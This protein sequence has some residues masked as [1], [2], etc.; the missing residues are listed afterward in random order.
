MRLENPKPEDIT[1]ALDRSVNGDGSIFCIENLPNVLDIAKETRVFVAGDWLA[2]GTIT[3]LTSESGHGKSYFSLQLASSVAEGNPFCGMQTAQRPVLYIDAE[4]PAEEVAGRL[5]LLGATCFNKFKIWGQWCEPEASIDSPAMYDWIERCEI[6]P[7]IVVDSL[8]AFH[9]GA[10]NSAEE[11]RR[12]LNKFRKLAGMGATIL[13]LHHSGKADTA[14]DYRGSSD[15]KAAIDV[16]YHQTNYG[17]S[18][19]GTVK[20]RA[21]KT[22]F[23]VPATLMFKFGPRGFE[24]VEETFRPTN[25]EILTE[26]LRANPGINGAAFEK[27]AATKDIPQFRARKFLIAGTNVGTIRVSKG[28]HNA[29]FYYFSEGENDLF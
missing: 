3:L 25:E 26:I 20:L 23:R 16:A 29:K 2:Q 22:R 19:L 28:E 11:T 27:L 5:R 6:K 1:T 12:Y 8:I 18:E 24:A 4:N 13:L 7:L 14:K 21:F 9:P 17:D 10:E 15:I